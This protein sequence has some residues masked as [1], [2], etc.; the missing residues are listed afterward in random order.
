MIT[1]KVADLQNSRRIR[2]G[3][4][5]RIAVCMTFDDNA[6]RNNAMCWGNRARGGGT[7][8]LSSGR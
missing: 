4:R 2:E 7:G 8:E 6:A 3:A 1:R 5:G